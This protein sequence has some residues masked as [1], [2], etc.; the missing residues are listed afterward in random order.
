[1]QFPQSD[2][3]IRINQILESDHHC[4]YMLWALLSLVLDHLF[5][6]QQCWQC[7]RT[8]NHRSNS[9]AGWCILHSHQLCPSYT[10]VTVSADV[11]DKFHFIVLTLWNSIIK[12]CK[13]H[14]IVL[15]LWNS[16]IK[17]CKST[18]DLVTQWGCP[19]KPWQKPWPCGVRQMPE[20]TDCFTPADI[21][22]I[23]RFCFDTPRL[24]TIQMATFSNKYPWTNFTTGQLE[25]THNA[26]RPRNKVTFLKTYFF[27]IAQIGCYDVT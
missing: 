21:K 2:Q 14:F 24:A 9:I 1:M 16:I 11:A 12:F 18:H 5:Q 6:Y 19:D 8:D 27:V 15:T 22:L 23:Q 13:F 26:I 10:V 3:T 20:L 4:L 25:I 7:F 17:F